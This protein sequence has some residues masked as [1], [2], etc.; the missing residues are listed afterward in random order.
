MN[1]SENEMTIDKI[2]LK[3]KDFITERPNSL[4]VTFPGN[5]C[6]AKTLMYGFMNGKNTNSLD[7]EGLE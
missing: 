1:E 4:F 5:I 6:I 3:S 2:A 7:I